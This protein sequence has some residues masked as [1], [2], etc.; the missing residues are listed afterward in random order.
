MCGKYNEVHNCLRDDECGDARISNRFQTSRW[1][2]CVEFV[3]GK[4]TL[5]FRLVQHVVESGVSRWCG[6]EIV[7]RGLLSSTRS[8]RL[9]QFSHP[10]RH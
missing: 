1:Y 6:R 8:W 9:A 3:C 10:V 4:T 5:S 7:K 2:T